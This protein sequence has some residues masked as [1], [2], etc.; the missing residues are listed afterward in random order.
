MPVEPEQFAVMLRQQQ[1]TFRAMNAA[2]AMQLKAA[3][4]PAEVMVALGGMDIAMSNLIDAV[5]EWA[6]LNLIDAVTEWA[7]EKKTDV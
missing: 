2:A 3:G 6:K 1:T 7:K 5:T 4:A